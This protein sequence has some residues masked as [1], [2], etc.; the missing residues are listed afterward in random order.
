MLGYKTVYS[1]VGPKIN[2]LLSAVGLFNRLY[3]TYAIHLLGGNTYVSFLEAELLDPPADLKI[4]NIYLDPTS[5]D[6]LV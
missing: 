1:S 2:Q 4:T 5:L 3:L 6:G